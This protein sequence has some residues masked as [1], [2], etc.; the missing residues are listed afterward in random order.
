RAARGPR[1]L[2]R[3][4]AGPAGAGGP[5]RLLLEAGTLAACRS[6][7]DAGALAAR[8]RAALPAAPMTDAVRLDEYDA[9]YYGR[10][11]GRPPLPVVRVRFADPMRT[12]IY[13]DATT[14]RTVHTVNR[15]G[16][17]ERW[18]FNGLHSLDFAFWYD[19]RPLWDIG[20]IVLMLG[21]L[22]STGIGVWLGA[23]RVRR[24]L[25]R[26]TAHPG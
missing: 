2:G 23:G 26:N 13:V 11:A 6:P 5:D 25:G 10:G 1:R 12:W 22:A 24:A 17:L 14:A 9:Y 18:L 16:R 21:G 3:G 7:V 20:L 15:Y 19:R 4:P 8:L